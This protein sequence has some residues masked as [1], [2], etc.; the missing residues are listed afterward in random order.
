MLSGDYTFLTTRPEARRMSKAHP[1]ILKVLPH[2]D[3]LNPTP[4]TLKARIYYT[5]ATPTAD[6]T[7]DTW[8]ARAGEVYSFQIGYQDVAYPSKSLAWKIEIYCGDHATADDMLFYYPYDYA[9][10]EIV[11]I[12]YTNSLGGIDSVICTMSD[13]SESNEFERVTA[14]MHPDYQTNSH[15]QRQYRALSAYGTTGW[16]V[17]TG[18][19]PSQADAEAL[20]DL[21]AINHAWVYD[22]I[23]GQQVYVPIYIEGQPVMPSQNSA[24]K[25]LAI[26][27]RLAVDIKS[28]SRS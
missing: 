3:K 15:N 20:R 12:Y 2:V 28:Y 24:I 21:W 18:P 14:V 19:M 6:Y 7:I 8:E 13:R 22:S 5:D 10:Q 23:G 1:E 4:Q 9:A 11:P 27:Y 26:S 17:I 16:E 25:S